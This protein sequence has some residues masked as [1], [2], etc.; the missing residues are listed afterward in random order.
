[1]RWMAGVTCA[2][3]ASCVR[4]LPWRSSRLTRSL[5]RFGSGLGSYRCGDYLGT[6]TLDAALLTGRVAAE[7]LLADH[8]L[9]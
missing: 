1:M 8:D 7:T 6:G 2:R 4:C 9:S 5:P 3:T